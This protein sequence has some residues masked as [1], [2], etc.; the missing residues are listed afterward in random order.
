MRGHAR[1]VP[2]SAL[3][4]QQPLA[5][6]LI[7][8]LLLFTD[9]CQRGHLTAGVIPGAISLGKRNTSVVRV[10]HPPTLF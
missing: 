2:R 3:L 1:R 7:S 9:H 5:A 4:I 8:I 6:A 10:I